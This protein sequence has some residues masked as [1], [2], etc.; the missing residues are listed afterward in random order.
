MFIFCTHSHRSSVMYRSSL[1]QPAQIV[2]VCVHLCAAFRFRLSCVHWRARALI[3]RR[4]CIAHKSN[5]A[6]QEREDADTFVERT[7]N[8]RLYVIVVLHTKA[9]ERKIY[10]LVEGCSFIHFKCICTLSRMMFSLK[11]RC[12]FISSRFYL[13]VSCVCTWNFRSQYV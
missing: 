6:T 7:I 8:H 2:C 10:E 11:K 1:S 12:M 3:E 13:C 4:R 5:L 9:R